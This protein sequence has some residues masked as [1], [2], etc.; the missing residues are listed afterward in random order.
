MPEEQKQAR[1]GRANATQRGFSHAARLAIL[2][3]GYFFISHLLSHWILLPVARGLVAFA[4]WLG[5]YWIPPRPEI[6]FA[7]W[8]EICALAAL[9]VF[10]LAIFLHIH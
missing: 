2:L 8:M 6:S 7:R 5:I 9:I 1:A 10:A 3:I 4:L